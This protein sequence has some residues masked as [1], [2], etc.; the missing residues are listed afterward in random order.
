VDVSPGT[1]GVVSVDETAPV[2]Y[3]ATIDIPSG[4]TVNLE[5]VPAPGFRFDRWDGD[6]TGNANPASIMMTCNKTVTV[7]FRRVVHTLTIQVDGQGSTT[8]EAGKRGYVSGSTV[9]IEAIADNGWQFDGWTGEVAEPASAAT[10]VTIDSDKTVTAN[11][12]EITHRLAIRLTGEGTT[13]PAGDEH[14]YPGGAMVNIT[15]TPD[16]GW[17][18]EGWSGGVSDPDA[19]STTVTMDSDKTITA[20]FSRV[21]HTLTM[22]V[23]GN[24]FTTPE[25]GTHSYGVGSIVSIQASPERGWRF[26]GWNGGVAKPKLASTTVSLDSEKVVT[27]SFSRVVPIWQVAVGIAAGTAVV[28]LAVWWGIR[29][30]NAH[31]GS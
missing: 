1:D 20:I 17:R 26:N 2:S 8:P 24:G 7:V 14:E 12:S 28:G 22:T 4:E 13:S 16:G 23:N 15:A 9:T 27:A 10:E 3:P 11:F 5:A 6:L 30:R 29:I 25:A 19:A 31:S 21:M 18:F